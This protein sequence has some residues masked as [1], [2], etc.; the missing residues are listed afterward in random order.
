MT[1]NNDDHPDGEEGLLPGYDA[2]PIG[3]DPR[4]EPRFGSFDKDDEDE[5][6]EPDRDTDYTSSFSAD[7]LDEDEEF[8]DD[9]PDEEENDHLLEEDDDPDYPPSSVWREPDQSVA[10]EPDDWLKKEGYLEENEDSSQKWPLSLIAVSI[11]ALVLLAAGGYGVMQQR[12]ATEEELRQLRAALATSAHNEDVSASPGALQE[13]KKSYDELAAT[14]EALTLENRRL[15][16][17]VAG[18][19]AQLGVQQAVIT[20]TVPT[21]K[22]VKPQVADAVASLYGAK[23]PPSANEIKPATVKQATLPQPA[24]PKP[25]APEPIASKSAATQP[26]ASKP[27]TGPSEPAASS[28]A[29]FVNFG[30]Y[31]SRSMAETWGSRLS[32]NAGKVIIAPY[33]K[34]GQTLYRVR[35]VK[36]ASK[37]SAEEVARKLE[38]ELRMPKLWIGKE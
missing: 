24:I 21:A 23:A 8:E 18:L 2:S 6:E 5:F 16:D 14:A 15:T 11:V 13:L 25:A 36:L 30:T 20:K 22:P 4:R 3:K 38:T 33:V 19:Q 10:E 35:V 32:P 7:S 29:W 26:V 37:G 17:T 12:A 9:F 28:G 1:R 27:A 34:D 31:A